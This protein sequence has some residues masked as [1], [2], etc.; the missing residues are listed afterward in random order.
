VPNHIVIK[1]ALLAVLFLAPNQA[2]AEA[3]PALGALIAEINIALDEALLDEAIDKAKKGQDA[4]LCQPEPVNPLAL[5]TIFHLKGAAH[6]FR[7]EE[8]DAER[9][10]EWA[11]SIAPG[12]SL[13]AVFGEKATELYNQVRQRVLDTPPGRVEVLDPSPTRVWVDGMEISSGVPMNLAAGPH[14]VQWQADSTTE[15]KA[16]ELTLTP[17]EQRTLNLTG[18]KAIS[19][20][21]LPKE[22]RSLFGENGPPKTM[23]IGGGG[24][25]AGTAALLLGISASQHRNFMQNATRSPE[26]ALTPEELTSLQGSINTLTTAGLGTGV[27]G[28]GLLGWGLLLDTQGGT[29]VSI[30]GRF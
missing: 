17:G 4:L 18:K 30:A 6:L 26:E 12:S 8:R 15:M 29:A 16:L 20:E 1:A 21:P 28:A 27:V 19:P 2:R 14:L 24:V 22:K 13:Q 9:A 11:A 3:C 7:G 10:F 23:V 25:L 5:S